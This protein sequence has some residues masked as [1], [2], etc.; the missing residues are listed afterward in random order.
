M[1]RSSDREIAKDTGIALSQVRLAITQLQSTKAVFSCK[2]INF[3]NGVTIEGTYTES[4]A[5]FDLRRQAGSLQRK[6]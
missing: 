5:I 4:L 2:G 6:C 1:V 3:N